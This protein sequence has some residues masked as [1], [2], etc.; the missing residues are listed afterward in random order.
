MKCQHIPY[1]LT[2]ENFSSRE[3]SH[4]FSVEYIPSAIAS[5]IALVLGPS[6]ST[7]P[8]ESATTRSGNGSPENF[9][10]NSTGYGG[11]TYTGSASL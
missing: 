1:D 7:G 9:G 10:W 4:R 2:R 11:P 6:K 5:T 8:G 3:R